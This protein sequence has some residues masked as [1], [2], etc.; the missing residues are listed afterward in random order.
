MTD[1]KVKK[2]HYNEQV[3]QEENGNF[4]LLVFSTNRGMGKETNKFYRRIAENLEE[5][6][7]KTD[8][9]RM[10]IWLRWKVLSL[11]MQSKCV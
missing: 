8:S 1:K 5:K 3:F 4:T 7:N 10:M 9:M 11:L 2:R 6:G